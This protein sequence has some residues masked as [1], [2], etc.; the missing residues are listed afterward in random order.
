MTCG[1]RGGIGAEPVRE[2]LAGREVT[3][4]EST[5]VH[6]LLPNLRRRMVGAWC[7]VDH[8]GPDN[9]AAGPGMPPHPHTGLQTVSWLLDGEVLH[10]DSLG[11]EHTLRP[12]QLG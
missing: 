12:G 6:R 8:H 2:L 4:G 9:I 5:G 7:F 3:I 1:G 10:L 11:S